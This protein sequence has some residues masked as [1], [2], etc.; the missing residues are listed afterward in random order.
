M[1]GQEEHLDSDRMREE[2]KERERAKRVR[3]EKRELYRI[4]ENHKFR[5][6]LMDH[7]L[8]SVAAISGG[9]GV[10]CGAAYSGVSFNSTTLHWLLISITQ[11]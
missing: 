3:R 11:S 9:G 6:A 1:S 10:L 5:L 8:G 7:M 4:R 2:K